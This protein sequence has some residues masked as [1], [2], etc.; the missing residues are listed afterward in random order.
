MAVV[1]P[2]Y[3]SEANYR[4][5][6]AIKRSLDPS[7]IFTPNKFC[8]GVGGELE[9]KDAVLGRKRKERFEDLHARRCKRLTC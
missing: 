2:L 6:C 4:R 8:V 3:H 5:L 9:S 7:G 1:W